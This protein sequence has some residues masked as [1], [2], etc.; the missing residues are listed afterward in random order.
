[1][2]RWHRSLLR[3]FLC[4]GLILVPLGYLTKGERL[5]MRWG[6]DK[7]GRCL[8]PSLNQETEE[9][10]RARI[11]DEAY[12]IVINGATE[13]AFSGD[14]DAFFEPGIY[15]DVIS[16]EPLFLSTDK[17]DSGCGW[18]AF[19]RPVE[20]AAVSE[21]ADYSHFMVRTEVRSGIS[22][23]HLGHVFE[24]GPVEAG[25]LRYC[26]NSKSLRFVPLEEM[27]QEGY[28]AYVD[29]IRIGLKREE[30]DTEMR[31]ELTENS[32][33]T[34]REIYLAGG[35]FWGTEAAFKS[36][37][38]VV[39]TEAGYANGTKEN[40]SYQEVCAGDTG[41]RET[42][43]I[44]YDPEQISLETILK[45]YF[46][47]IDPT[48]ENQ[49]GNDR[50]SQYQ[51]GV[52]YSDEADLPLLTEIFEREKEKSTPFCVELRKLSAFYPAEEYHQDYLDKNPA[53]YCHISRK[54]ME[55]VRKLNG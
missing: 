22:G 15:V 17:Y 27:Q 20:E 48:V 39:D 31:D 45:G 36:L 13:R 2:K 7:A 33:K 1:M 30:A 12:E 9:A 55:E 47:V 32:R 43:R 24:D 10:L 28:G 11:G 41:H 40:P 21:M 42:V 50:G 23:A 44:L 14:Y 38:G 16:G 52:Y 3:I 35:C 46:M 8:N 54:E 5:T 19:T 29:Q 18:P 37:N 4:A 49:Q 26:I 34:T 51:T 53:G 6:S 25:G